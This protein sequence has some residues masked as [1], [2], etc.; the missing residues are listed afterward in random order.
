MLT[1]PHDLTTA[2]NAI[3]ELGLDILIYADIGMDPFSYYL[4]FSRLAPIQC[5]FWGHPVTSGVDTLD[6]YIS[7]D[8]A[9]PCAAQEHYTERL[10]RLGGVQ[11]CYHRPKLASSF[12]RQKVGLPKIKLYICVLKSV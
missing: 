2:Q 5:V 9:E 3:S 11:T 1:V 8:I 7:S 10:V 6:F 12:S 4:S